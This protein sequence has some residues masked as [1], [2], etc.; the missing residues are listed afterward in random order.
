[1][2]AFYSMLNIV[3][4]TVTVKAKRKGWTDSYITR[5]FNSQLKKPEIALYMKYSFSPNYVKTLYIPLNED[6]VAEDWEV[7][8]VD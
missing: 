6:L 8:Q 4:N 5:E 7:E 3:L 2:M 1:M